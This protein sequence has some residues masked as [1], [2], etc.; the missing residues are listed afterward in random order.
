MAKV[1]R[2]DSYEVK[3]GESYF[4]DNNVWMLLFSPI[5]NSKPQSQRKYA[6]LLREIRSRGGM[7]FVSSL[8]LS[9]YVNS[10]LRLS[11]KLWE[12]STG[13]IGADY[14]RDYRP[15]QEYRDE[16]AAV[17][18]QVDEILKITERKPD[19]FNSIHIDGVLKNMVNSDFNDEY[20]IR[21][22][23]LNNLKLVTDDTD[24]LST[25][26]NVEIITK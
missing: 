14:K 9:E 2:I 18:S 12:K 15:T 16:V 24:I 5:V 17:E 8:I 10:N 6:K 3:S 13:N 21:L 7:I 26:R 23:E 11:F 20:Y 19:D 1:E 4:F 25:P 22:C